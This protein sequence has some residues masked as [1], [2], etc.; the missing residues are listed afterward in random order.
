MATVSTPSSSCNA[1][2]LTKSN[3]DTLNIL[4][5]TFDGTYDQ[6]A[7]AGKYEVFYYVEDA[8]TGDLSPRERSFVYKATDGNPAPSSF[9]EQNPWDDLGETRGGGQ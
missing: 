2:T 4:G 7:E 3:Q 8:A 6:F 9:D 1:I 5:C